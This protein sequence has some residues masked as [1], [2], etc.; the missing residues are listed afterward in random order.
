MTTCV[1]NLA[2][3]ASVDV[4]ALVRFVLDE[5]RLLNA[6]D[7]DAW[8]ALFHAQCRY[9]VPLAGDRQEDSPLHASLADEDRYLLATRIRRLKSPAAHSLDPGVRS[10]H[11]IQQ[12][13]V[14]AAD[15]DD[16]LLR[17]PFL[18]TETAGARQLTLAGTWRH[19]LRPTSDGLRIV[20]KRV[21]LLQAGAAHEIIQ[22]FP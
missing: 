4:D 9:W 19:R 13:E 8:L 17:T 14:E 5:V 6:G 2:A 22:L 16:H 18:Y 21:D 20:C 12:P 1:S 7:F 3:P 15:G 10:L 11:V